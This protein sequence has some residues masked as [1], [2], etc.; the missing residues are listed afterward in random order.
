MSSAHA[1]GQI[2]C[3]PK[4]QSLVQVP[5]SAPDSVEDAAVGQPHLAEPLTTSRTHDLPSHSPPE[6]TSA[7]TASGRNPITSTSSE[8]QKEFSHQ[9]NPTQQEPGPA[10][11][12]LLPPTGD[13][14]PASTQRTRQWVLYVLAAAAGIALAILTASQFPD[15][16]SDNTPIAAQLRTDDSQQASSTTHSTGEKA[17]PAPL[18]PDRRDSVTAP[19][20]AIPD[21]V[22]AESSVNAPPAAARS[23]EERTIAEPNADPPPL[24]V[25]IENQAPHDTPAPIRP[26][27]KRKA[28]TRHLDIDTQIARSLESFEIHRQPLV[29][30]ARFVSEFTYLPVTLDVVSLRQH[31]I[32][33]LVPVSA[34]LNQTTFRDLL[35][36]LLAPLELKTTFD[37]HQGIIIHH[38]THHPEARARKIDVRDLAT[39]PTETEQL[40]RLIQTLVAPSTWRTQGG[41]GSLQGARGTLIVYQTH[42]IHTE[43]ERF[44]GQLRRAR[45]KLPPLKLNPGNHNPGAEPQFPLVSLTF[46]QP[47]RLLQMVKRLEQETDSRLVVNW[48]SLAQ[49]GWYADSTSTLVANADP[50]DHVLEQLF[51]PTPVTLSA[52]GSTLY[53]VTTETPSEV[54]MQIMFHPTGQNLTLDQANQQIRSLVQIIGPAHFQDPGSSGAICFDALSDCLIVRLPATLQS[55]VESQLRRPRDF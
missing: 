52:L 15:W 11:R 25:A 35:P 51:Q 19:A 17:G 2:L 33:P 9:A 41:T 4:C 36:A 13:W 44:C 53:H 24:P 39:N 42:S 3:C 7:E 12:P 32:S 1:L 23:V 49:Q 10:Y 8:T 40:C 27:A 45:K 5:E 48:A 55:L 47:T 31:E 28:A 54:R 26:P 6:T 34:E 38:R 43:V 30:F 14:T 16:S 46:S 29:D 20:S 50:L 22:T 18:D 37:S 21:V